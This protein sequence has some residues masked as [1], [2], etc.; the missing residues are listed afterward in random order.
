MPFFKLLFLVA[1]KTICLGKIQS[2]S[3]DSNP[4]TL[5]RIRPVFTV[6]S[7]D[8]RPQCCGSLSGNSWRARTRWPWA[9]RGDAG[10]PFGH[11]AVSCP[12]QRVGGGRGSRRSRMSATTGR[13]PH[14]YLT[15]EGTHQWRPD[16]VGLT[17]ALARVPLL[18]ATC[19][20][21]TA[22]VHTLTD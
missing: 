18:I 8:S 5:S 16:K 11:C 17:H 12:R 21:A 14:S 7:L 4:G 15:W 22:T 2:S 10:C 13:R 1:A 6:E 19:F 3:R 20:A 9:R